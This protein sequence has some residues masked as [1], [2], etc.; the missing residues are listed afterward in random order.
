MKY[1][2]SNVDAVPNTVRRSTDERDA[3]DSTPT[4]EPTADQPEPVIEQ[5]PQPL[6]KPLP[7]PET[8]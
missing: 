5:T 1:K 6:A 3:L 2:D 7:K 8:A 4:S